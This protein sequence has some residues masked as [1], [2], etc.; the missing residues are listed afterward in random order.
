MQG[1]IEAIISPF[2]SSLATIIAA[3]ALKIL[4]PLAVRSFGALFAA[5]VLFAVIKKSKE[6]LD[7]KA[8]KSSIPDLSKLILLRP[9]IGNLFLV[10]GLSLTSGIKAIFFTK[11]EPY[12]VLFWHWF[13]RKEKVRLK[14]VVLLFFHIAGALIL[15]TGGTFRFERT[16]MGDLLIIISMFFLSLSYFYAEKF[17]KKLGAKSTVAVTEGIAGVVLLPFVF[18]FVP[19]N[20]YANLSLL[21]PWMY[22]IVAVLLFTVLSLTLWYSSLKTVKGWMV[23][24]LRSLGPILGAPVAWI[25][26]G[27]KLTLIQIGGAVVILVTSSLIAYEHLSKESM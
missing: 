11:V 16:Q 23:S 14:H 9:L 24:A 19:V 3:Q 13:L 6:K 26:F 5:L 7:A 25:F 15:S 2:F 21:V 4:N 12:F 18:L 27:Q 8:I 10:Y 17:S 20:K 22:I 1:L